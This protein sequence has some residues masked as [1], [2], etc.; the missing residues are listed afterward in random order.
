MV[1][2]VGLEPTASWSQI[3]R[4]SQTELIP[5]IKMVGIGGFE[6]P[7]LRLSV[8]RSNQLSYIPVNKAQASLN[9]WES[10]PRFFRGREMSYH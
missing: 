3:T 6:P 9:K 4:S 10:N 2:D 7:T 8:V 1:G 5:E